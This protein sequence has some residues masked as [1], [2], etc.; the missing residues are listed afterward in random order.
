[1]LFGLNL[2]LRINE[3]LLFYIL[4]LLSLNIILLQNLVHPPGV[5]SFVLVQY[6]FNF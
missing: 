4:N 2:A 1:M 3:L 5:E 6:L